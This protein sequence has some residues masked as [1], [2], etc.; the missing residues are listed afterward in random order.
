MRLGEEPFEKNQTEKGKTD[1]D[2][3][4]FCGTIWL[5][6]KFKTFKAFL[7]NLLESK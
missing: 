5:V 2:M 3:C 6:D 7:I 4:V 1:T